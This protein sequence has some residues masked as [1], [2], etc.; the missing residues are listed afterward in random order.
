MASDY[1]YCLTGWRN[2]A[3]ENSWCLGS[4]GLDGPR[5]RCVLGVDAA[6]TEPEY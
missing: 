6:G 3:K 2:F 1:G 4:S 5:R